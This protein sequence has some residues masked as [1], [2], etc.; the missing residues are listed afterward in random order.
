M[1]TNSALVIGDINIDLALHAKKY[2]KEG[3]ETHADKM[4]FRL[5]GSGC[6][7][8]ACL[9]LMGVP[10]SLSAALGDD[11]FGDFAMGHI[12]S[13]GIDVSLIHRITGGQTG[14][15]MILITPGGGRTMFGARGAN[16]QAP[17]RE[18]LTARLEEVQHLHI[19]GYALHED[20]QF[21]TVRETAEAASEAGVT[22]SL[23]PGYCTSE[24]KGERL[25]GMLPLVDWL[26]PSKEELALL[27][28][29]ENADTSLERML[30]LGCGAVALKMGNEG[31]MYTNGEEWVQVKAV[32]KP[33]REIYDTTCAGDCF[34]AGFLKGML[35]GSG[36]QEA[37]RM[38]N[39]AAFH[40]IT[41]PKGIISLIEEGTNMEFFDLPVK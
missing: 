27:T 18:E 15:F 29:E 22:V 40:L 33:G 5:G 34:N 3:G 13:S 28:G 36:P 20:E 26:L 7:T 16:S 6:A 35:E 32:E 19:S 4:E 9:S 14:F 2:P 41:S 24:S 31:S 37:L 30:S 10:T 12:Q 38:G 39:Q 1:A 11:L 23:D 8:A 17:D 25:L 21:A